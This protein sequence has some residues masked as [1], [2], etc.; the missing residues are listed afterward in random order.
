MSE[1]VLGL[2]LALVEEAWAAE[3][4]PYPEEIRVMQRCLILSGYPTGEQGRPWVDGVIGPN[5]RRALKQWQEEKGLEAT[6]RFDEAARRGLIDQTAKWLMELPQV[7]RTHAKGQMI[8]LQEMEPATG[9]F[10]VLHYLAAATA[11][12]DEELV[13]AFLA[14]YCACNNG[15]ALAGLELSDYL[16]RLA[17]G[18]DLATARRLALRY[19]FLQLSGDFIAK[20]PDLDLDRAANPGDLDYQFD[21]IATMLNGDEALRKVAA[22]L[23]GRALEQ[24]F[25]KSAVGC[26]M[27]GPQTIGAAMA[28][29]A[30]ILAKEG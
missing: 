6:G 23:N 13:P 4:G 29:I 1:A 14:L 22:K 18:E 15:V 25:E 27:G 5:T 10:A 9:K 30:S 11:R 19:G 28:E 20:H 12:V 21:V 7:Q 17:A 2:D 3:D 24:A 8:H 16:R 26:A